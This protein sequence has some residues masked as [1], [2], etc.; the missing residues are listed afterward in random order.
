MAKRSKKQNA[1]GKRKKSTPPNANVSRPLLGQTLQVPKSRMSFQAHGRGGLRVKGL[2]VVAEVS[3]IHGSTLILNQPFTPAD[4]TLFPR[5]SEIANVFEE[6][7]VK[8]MSVHYSPICPSTLTGRISMV[9]NHDPLEQPEPSVL[10]IGNYECSVI[11]SVTSRLRTPVWR[12]RDDQFYKTDPSNSTAPDLAMRSP[13]FLTILVDGSDSGDDDVA[14]GVLAIEYDVI[15][16]HPQPT[17]DETS[18]AF[19]LKNGEQYRSSTLQYVAKIS[20]I[21]QQNG[22]SGLTP[23]GVQ[24]NPAFVDAAALG[25]TSNNSSYVDAFQA[26]QSAFRV[27]LAAASVDSDVL[28]KDPF[29]GKGSGLIITHDHFRGYSLLNKSRLTELQESKDPQVQQYLA[30]VIDCLACTKDECKVDDQG[31]VVWPRLP[32]AAGDVNLGFQYHHIVGSGSGNIFITT[33]SL[34]TGAATY[35]GAGVSV[36]LTQAAVIYFIV[37]PT[38]TEIRETAEDEFNYASWMLFDSDYLSQKGKVGSLKK[39][40]AR[41]KSKGNALQM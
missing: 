3:T 7:H 26:V 23:D 36:E 6:Y 24:P 15:L 18:C 41:L 37:Q 32:E 34:G 2:E 4:R 29:R 9:A 30:R 19:S 33:Y 28:A 27:A 31:N 14:C 20:Q 16:E 25:L 22:I 35:R 8:S 12:P 21:L 40:S 39:R 1:S 38:G 10:M 17:R 11:G 13:G 5:L